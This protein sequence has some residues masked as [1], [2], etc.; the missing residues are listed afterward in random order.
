[1]M[2]GI[3]TIAFDTICLLG[4]LVSIYERAAKLLEAVRLRL[5]ARRYRKTLVSETVP[6]SRKTR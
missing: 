1:M 3:I 5:K 4:M 6:R 2:W